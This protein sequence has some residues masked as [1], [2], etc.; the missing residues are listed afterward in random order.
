M[1]EELDKLKRENEALKS[2]LSKLENQSAQNMKSYKWA[3]TLTQEEVDFIVEMKIV[4]EMI[5]YNSYTG[6][7][8]VTTIE[9]VIDYVKKDIEPEGMSS[10]LKDLLSLGLITTFA[11]SKALLGYLSYFSKDSLDDDFDVM[12]MFDEEQLLTSEG[13]CGK[14]YLEVLINVEQMTGEGCINEQ[15]DVQ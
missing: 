1:S 11:L 6:D 14:M 9:K 12:F 4:D 8:H 7:S 13:I 5:D 3:D 2:K 15:G 10:T